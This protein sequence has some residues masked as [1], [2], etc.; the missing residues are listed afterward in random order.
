MADTQ[1]GNVH[2]VAAVGHTKG[3]I[4]NVTA[5]GVNTVTLDSVIGLNAGDQIDIIDP[6]TG[7]VLAADRNVS[8]IT[9]AGV[10][11]YSGADVTATTSHDVFLA[12]TFTATGIANLNGGNA[13]DA[14]Y[15][16][17]DLDTIAAMKARLAA[18][19]SGL[20]TAAYLNQM[21]YNDMVYAIRLNDS[22]TTI[23]S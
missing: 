6:A 23:N 20:Y 10:V 1:V 9:D 22:P 13:V 5:D 15:S 11:T 14:G 19:N 16:D 8:N 2:G 18:I 4:G 21:T 3:F 12:G 17:N 7:T